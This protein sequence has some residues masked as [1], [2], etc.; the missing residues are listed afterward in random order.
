MFLTFEDLNQLFP[1]IKGEKD[2]F[3]FHFVS[4]NAA[5]HQPKGLF[6]PLYEDSGEM[7]EAISNGAIGAL[8]DEDKEVPSYVPSQFPLFFTSD[9]EESLEQVLNTYVKQLDG[10]SN[11][12]KNMTKFLFSQEKILNEM[13]HSYYK[14]V[15]KFVSKMEGRE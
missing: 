14:P 10:E 4:T 12:M 2:A 9:L 5:F 8:W 7:K 15:L 1:K 3:Q 11:E 13:Y 6:L